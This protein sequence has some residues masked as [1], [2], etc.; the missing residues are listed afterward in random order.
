VPVSKHSKRRREEGNFDIRKGATLVIP[1]RAKS[2]KLAFLVGMMI[3]FL[4][5]ALSY[6]QKR[7]EQQKHLGNLSY[8]PLKKFILI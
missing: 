8:F 4:S 3:T 1:W 6:L 5:S 2:S 7:L